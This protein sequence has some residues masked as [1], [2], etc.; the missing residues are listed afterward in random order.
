MSMK[1]WI[2]YGMG[3][4]VNCSDEALVNFI[5]KHK[6]AFCGTEEE[7]RLF[8]ELRECVPD[9]FYLD[10]IFELYECDVSGCAGPGAAISNIMSRETGISF[11]YQP[12][13]ID[14]GSNHTVLLTESMPWHYSEE[15]KELTEDKLIAILRK[16]AAELGINK[17]DV[18]FCEVEYY[19]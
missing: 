13:D 14:C 19:G 4:E 10:D 1:T 15:D 18:G 12:G 17:N 3:F 9:I 16:Y 7:V 6:T 5:K 11:E 8:A 2:V